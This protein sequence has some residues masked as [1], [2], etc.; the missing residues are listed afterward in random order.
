MKFCWQ[1]INEI[2]RKQAEALCVTQDQKDLI[3]SVAESIAEAEEYTCWKPMLLQ[4]DDE[5]IGF[6]MYGVWVDPNK[7]PRM[8]LDRFLIDKHYQGKG[9]AK[10]ILPWILEQ[11]T[12]VYDE[13]YLSV[14]ETNTVAIA[15]YKQLGFS[16]NGE[17]DT[18]GEKVMVWK[19]KDN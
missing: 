5:A 3:E 11:I 17:I 1:N 4:K 18:K 12:D 9:Y 2:N 8:W 16:F 13:V 19:K 15:L 6:A 14:Y 7:P 10:Q